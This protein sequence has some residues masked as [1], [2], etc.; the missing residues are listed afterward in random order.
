MRTAALK[1]IFAVTP[2]HVCDAQIAIA[3][4]RAGEVGILD[5][6]PSVSESIQTSMV[7]KLAKFAGHAGLW[8]VRC[9]PTDPRQVADSLE[10][11]GWSDPVSAEDRF[12][13]SPGRA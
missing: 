3:A 7:E 11:R 4:C 8:G 2:S 12:A 13:Q 1:R 6:C 9:C 5:L 10:V